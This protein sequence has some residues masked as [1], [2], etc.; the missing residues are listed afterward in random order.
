MTRSGLGLYQLIRLTIG[1]YGVDYVRGFGGE[2]IQSMTAQ[3]EGKLCRKTQ[4]GH[5]LLRRVQASDPTL[6]EI[7]QNSIAYP[8]TLSPCT[9]MQRSD[10]RLCRVS[11]P[12]TSRGSIGRST[13]STSKRTVRSGSIFRLIRYIARRCHDHWAVWTRLPINL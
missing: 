11:R 4:H 9:K 6:S 1:K 5:A 12:G 13:R 2:Q 8:N 7:R 10:T 3:S